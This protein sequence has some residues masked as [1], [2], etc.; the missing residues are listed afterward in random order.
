MKS[1]HGTL[2]VIALSASAALAAKPKVEP[3]DPPAKTTAGAKTS[4][5]AA[6]EM[7]APDADDP[8]NPEVPAGALDAARAARGVEWELEIED[9]LPGK[10]YAKQLDFFK[11]ELGA[12]DAKG[13]VQYASHLAGTRPDR[14]NGKRED[15]ERFTIGW[16]KGTLLGLD[17]K[18]LVKAGINTNGKKILQFYPRDV[19]MQMLKLEQAY[20]G[21]NAPKILRTRFKI[22]P[23]DAQPGYEFYVAEQDIKSDV[24]SKPSSSLNTGTN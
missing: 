2:V 24:P 14:R 1:F 5:K 12:E 10:E 18:L 6:T 11:I 7:P 17:R 21:K 8:D 3:P 15:D 20:A 23:K 22:R 19:E 4:D 16:K 9:G 13:Q